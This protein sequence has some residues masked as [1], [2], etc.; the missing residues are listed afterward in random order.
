MSHKDNCPPTP[1]YHWV[2]NSISVL[3]VSSDS[4]ATAHFTPSGPTHGWSSSKA[5]AFSVVVNSAIR[6]RKICPKIFA[7]FFL[8]IKQKHAKLDLV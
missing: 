7:I 4:L 5:P 3:S 1:V 2:F 6:N 8:R